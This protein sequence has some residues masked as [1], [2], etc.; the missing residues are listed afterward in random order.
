MSFN[1]ARDN[2]NSYY[3]VCFV[4]D[5]ERL[6]ADKEYEEFNKYLDIIFDRSALLDWIEEQI[7]EFETV[8]TNLK[9]A[10]LN[11]IDI[12]EV[13]KE[14]NDNI[15]EY[16][17]CEK[18]KLFFHYDDLNDCDR[19]CGVVLCSDCDDTHNDECAERKKEHTDYECDTC[20]PIPAN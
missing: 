2:T 8:S 15:F 16:S 12:D 4:E 7:D 14:I 17:S 1:P 6:Y 13:A 5:I 20:V 9:H 19:S 10:I 18:C 3:A 11:G